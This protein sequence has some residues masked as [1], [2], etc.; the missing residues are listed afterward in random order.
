MK[1]FTPSPLYTMLFQS[2]LIL[3]QIRMHNPLS[4][5]V[6]SRSLLLFA[7]PLA[8]NFS[9]LFDHSFLLLISPSPH[10]HPNALFSLPSLYSS[11]S[12]FFSLFPQSDPNSW[13]DLS[14]PCAL[15][16]LK[17]SNPYDRAVAF[18]LLRLVATHQ[19]IVVSDVTFD[20]QELHLKQVHQ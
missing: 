11:P 7:S 15:Y 10:P 19:R 4:S 12:P 3:F 14:S 8:T 5:I 16:N 2:D 1:T 17:L 6:T 13:F 20:G 9:Y 18:A